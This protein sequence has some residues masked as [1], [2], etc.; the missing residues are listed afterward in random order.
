MNSSEAQE[1]AYSPLGDGRITELLDVSSSGSA[2]DS[3][4]SGSQGRFSELTYLYFPRSF[5]LGEMLN[6]ACF[7][8]LMKLPVF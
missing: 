2:D 6:L 4:T 1:P 5:D 8:A 3:D 7:F